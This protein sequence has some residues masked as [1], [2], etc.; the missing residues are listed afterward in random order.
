MLGE[1]KGR[2]GE[3][4]RAGLAARSRDDDLAGMVAGVNRVLG[5]LCRILEEERPGTAARLLVAIE[6]AANDPVDGYNERVAETMR[7]MLGCT[8]EF[9]VGIGN[10]TSP[11][12]ASHQW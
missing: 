11:R 7:S 6:E 9:L 3:L 1:L 12:I 4:E 8:E 5:A 10:F 2:L